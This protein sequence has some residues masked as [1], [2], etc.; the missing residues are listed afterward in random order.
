MLLSFKAICRCLLLI[1]IPGVLGCAPGNKKPS[2]Q[3][4]VGRSLPVSYAKGF[5]ITDHG[6]YRKVTVFDPWE[7]SSGISFEY[8]LVDRDKELPAELQGKQVIR[9]PVRSVICLS[10]SHIGFLSA[11]DEIPSLKALSGASYVSDTEVQ[12]LIA[13]KKIS[14]VGYD[15][16]INYELILSLKPDLIMVYGVGGEV[17]GF[18]NKLRDLGLN[19][20]LNGE[21]LEETPLAKAEWVKFVGAFYNKDQEAADYFSKIERNYNEIKHKVTAKNRPVVLTG[22]PY[23]DAWWMAGGH[24]NLAAFITDAGGEFLWHDN[25]SREAFVVSLEEVV[26]R[27]VKADFWINCG[28]VNT[29]NELISADSR[30]ATF[31]QVQKKSIFNNNLAMSVGGGNDYWER[32]VV[33]PDL[34]LSD[35]VKIFH[36]ECDSS[37]VFNFYKKME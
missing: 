27:S 30:F 31:P 7:Q 24:S 1:I 11:L 36:P 12:K 19:V 17:T 9:T 23:K 10:T 32:G 33:R 18:I 34:I 2:D 5:V 29:L 37:K 16:G 21:Y 6:K 25:T 20:I 15:Q 13:S 22:L 3:K 26:V 35:L 4:G 14:D 8:Y 28:T